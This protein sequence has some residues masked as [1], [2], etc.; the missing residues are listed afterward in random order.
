MVSK[1]AKTTFTQLF[2]PPSTARPKPLRKFFEKLKISRQNNF[3]LVGILQGKTPKETLPKLKWGRTLRKSS[4][5]FE[6]GG[7]K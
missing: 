2:Y 5:E 6:G 7:V 4:F 1:L 3:Y